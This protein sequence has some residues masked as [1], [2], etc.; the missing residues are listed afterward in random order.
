MASGPRKVYGRTKSEV[1]D[2][3]KVLHEELDQ[4]VRPSASDKMAEALVD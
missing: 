2:R 1:K 3:L 4:G